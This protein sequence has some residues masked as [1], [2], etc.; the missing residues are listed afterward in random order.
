[1]SAIGACCAEIHTAARNSTAI[2]TNSRGAG[3]EM[4]YARAV[5]CCPSCQSRQVRRKHV[6]WFARIAKRLTARRPYVCETC[7]WRGWRQPSKQPARQQ[8]PAT[9]W[10]SRI[11]S[12]ALRF[13][14]LRILHRV[15]DEWFVSGMRHLRLWRLQVSRSEVLRLSAFFALGLGAGVFVVWNASEPSFEPRSPGTTTPMTETATTGTGSP[16]LPSP[17]ASNSP[18]ASVSQAP[19]IAPRVPS[20][21]PP[22][23]APQKSARASSRS[24]PSTPAPRSATRTPP[25]QTNG[26]TGRSAATT[27]ARPHGSLAI[28]SAPSGARVSFNGRAVGS[29]PVVL[30]NVPAGTHLVRIEADGYQPWAW[31]ARVVGNRQN[32]LT[33][34][35]SGSAIR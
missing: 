4:E 22:A 14:A 6:P 28:E 24:A 29:T 18:V 8:S 31:T 33:V 10:T 2:S 9:Q 5:D 32:R 17:P 3:R 7:G 25:Q 34:K 21:R 26:T 11:F 27:S 19:T 30:R 23:R 16:A 12:D 13:H 35:L 20:V 15:P 1:M